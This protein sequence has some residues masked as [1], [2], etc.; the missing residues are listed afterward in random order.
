[1]PLPLLIGAGIYAAKLTSDLIKKGKA[2]KKAK[3][4]AA[5]RP[6]YQENPLY[7]D[8]LDLAESEV[9]GLSARGETAYNQLRDK[10]FSNSMDAIL[11]SGG[12]ANNISELYSAGEEGRLRLAELNDQ[13]RMNQIQNLIRAREQSANQG[14]KAWQVNV[15]APWKDQAQAVSE[16]RKSAEE[17]IW[18][19]VSGLGGMAM[20]YFGG[21]NNARAYNNYGNPTQSTP[22]SIYRPATNVLQ[23]T[24]LNPSQMGAGSTMTNMS[25]YTP[26]TF[27]PSMR[28]SPYV[29][30]REQYS[31]PGTWTN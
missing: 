23:G 29:R 19:S 24:T 15:D 18:S 13:L 12:S 14:D 20:Q 27:N 10:Q 2:K 25:G 17:G 31:F 21:A 1:M 22:T 26:N 28:V 8:N 4:L 3:Q 11:K 16:A 6:Q 7:Q 9:G 30:Y 5:N